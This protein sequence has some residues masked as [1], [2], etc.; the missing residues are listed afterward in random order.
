M[1]HKRWLLVNFSKRAP[2]LS[3]S[4]HQVKPSSLI[5]TTGQSLKTNLLT[6]CNGRNYKSKRLI[7]VKTK[8]DSKLQGLHVCIVAPDV[9]SVSCRRPSTICRFCRPFSIF[10]LLSQLFALKMKE[11]KIP[12][13]CLR[14]IN[15]LGR[16][17]VSTECPIQNCHKVEVWS[18]KPWYGMV[19][20]GMAW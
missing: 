16:D 7:S 18:G 8:I 10:V 17:G 11:P 4:W 19:R 20:H 14:P 9:Y 15:V 12:S 3:H 5:G 6:R 1:E 13:I 2:L